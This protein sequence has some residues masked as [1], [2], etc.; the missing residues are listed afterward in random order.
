MTCPLTFPRVPLVLALLVALATSPALAQKGNKPIKD[1]DP[2]TDPE[3]NPDTPPTGS[4]TWVPLDAYGATGITNNGD[5]TLFNGQLA[6]ADS[7][8]GLSY[9]DLQGHLIAEGLIKPFD[10]VEGGYYSLAILD[11]NVFRQVLGRITE[12]EYTKISETETKTTYYYHTFVYTPGLPSFLPSKESQ[13]D[14]LNRVTNDTD[15][16]CLNDWGVVAGSGINPDN[17]ERQ[18]YTWNMLDKVQTWLGPSALNG[19]PARQDRVSDINNDGEIC[20][21]NGS[22]Y[23]WRYSSTTGFSVVPSNTRLYAGSSGG[24]NDKGQVTGSIDTTKSYDSPYDRVAF[25]SDRNGTTLTVKL[26][27]SGKSFGGTINIHGD[28]L[29]KGDLDEVGNYWRPFLYTDTHGVVDL[30]TN[31]SNLPPGLSTLAAWNTVEVRG[32]NDFGIIVGYVAGAGAETD[33]AF[34]L[35]PVSSSN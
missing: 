23:P 12:V 2:V 13:L 30:L 10:A 3:P 31:T 29:G 9:I 33:G 32:L 5:I 35:V 28:F 27:K 8:G 4:Y 24:I 19:T 16:A 18:V 6:L 20:G 1:P 25:R 22:V 17:L 21:S 14:F 26:P 11:I 7:T 15:S 34:M